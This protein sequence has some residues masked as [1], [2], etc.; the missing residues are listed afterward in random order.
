MKELLI[1]I[2]NSSVA[3]LLIICILLDV[4][5]GVFRSIKYGKVNSSTGIDGLIR[6][7]SMF[8]VIVCTQAIDMIFNFNVA[9]YLPEQMVNFLGVT[10]IGVAEAFAT[11]FIL[12]EVISIF[13]NMLLCGLPL[14]KGLVPKLYN[15]LDK[16][17]DEVVDFEI[18]EGDNG[19][20]KIIPK[21]K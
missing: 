16:W 19:R 13:K 5:L 20:C 21:T 18:V 10:T 8:I 11:I 3:K 4:V 12:C 1:M 15:M 17:T 14:P 9:Q 6:K 2:A 7:S